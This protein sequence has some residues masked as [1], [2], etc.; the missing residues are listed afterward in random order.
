MGYLVYPWGEKI[1]DRVCYKPYV[2]VYLKHEVEVIQYFE[3]EKE[4]S[5]WVESLKTKS[6]RDFEVISHKI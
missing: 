2:T 1:N 3:T 6:G 5:R 4:A